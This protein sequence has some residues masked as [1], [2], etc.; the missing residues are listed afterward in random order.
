[1]YRGSRRQGAM[2][3]SVYGVCKMPSAWVEASTRHPV[4]PCLIQSV[5]GIRDVNEVNEKPVKTFV[6]VSEQEVQR[7]L[8]ISRPLAPILPF[9]I[10]PN[11]YHLLATTHNVRFTFTPLSLRGKYPPIAR[12]SARY[13]TFFPAFRFKSDPIFFPVRIC[14]LPRD[15]SVR[16]R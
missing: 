5:E 6:A 3:Y 15:L 2:Y 13:A 8:T 16:C 12:L 1:V 10:Q 9:P 4:C 14:R 11:P 7:G